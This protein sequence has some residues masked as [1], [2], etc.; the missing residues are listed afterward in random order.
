MNPIATIEQHETIRN[1]IGYNLLSQIDLVDLP[2][3]IE[4]LTVVNNYNNLKR[5]ENG[6]KLINNQIKSFTL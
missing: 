5:I 2:V 6:N 4:F 1:T 3:V